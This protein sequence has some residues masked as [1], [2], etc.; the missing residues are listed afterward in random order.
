[1]TG[2]TRATWSGSRSAGPHR[3]WGGYVNTACETKARPATTDGCPILAARQGWEPSNLD[4]PHSSGS[5]RVEGP[6]LLNNTPRKSN[7]LRHPVFITRSSFPAIMEADPWKPR[8]TQAILL[9]RSS[10]GNRRS[11][12]ESR[13]GKP[14]HRHTLQPRDLSQPLDA[15]ARRS[16]PPLQ[17]NAGH[18]WSG[19]ERRRGHHLAHRRGPHLAGGAVPLYHSG[20]R[21]GASPGRLGDGSGGPRE[22]GAWRAQRGIRPAR[23]IDDSPGH[24]VD[25]LRLLPP[26]ATRLSRHRTDPH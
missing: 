20:A 9:F 15:R 26:A 18:I 3:S 4:R 11:L 19:R 23:R 2:H 17:R 14:I 24:S 22:T 21:P 13:P 1:M 8:S 5:Q 7:Y 10:R 12:D 25:R 6:P 16:N